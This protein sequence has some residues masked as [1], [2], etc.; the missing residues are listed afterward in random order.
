MRHRPFHNSFAF[1]IPT[2]DGEAWERHAARC[3]IYFD[4]Y[5]GRYINVGRWI[6]IAQVMVCLGLGGCFERIVESKDVFGSI[7]QGG[8]TYSGVEHD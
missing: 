3:L 6:L 7:K 1:D 8:E 5:R 4:E 2:T